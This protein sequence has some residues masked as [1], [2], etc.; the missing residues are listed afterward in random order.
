LLLL[1]AS[2]AFLFPLIQSIELIGYTIF[3][4]FHNL[5]NLIA[6]NDVEKKKKEKKKKEKRTNRGQLQHCK[7]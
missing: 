4:N 1:Q 5:W 2:D 6:N 7:S 3:Q